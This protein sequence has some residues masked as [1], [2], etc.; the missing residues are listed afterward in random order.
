MLWFYDRPNEQ[1]RV[2]ARYDNDTAEFVVVV[3]WPDGREQTE[4]FSALHEFQAW[5]TS[6]DGAMAAEQWRPNT[7]IVLP[8]GWPDKRLT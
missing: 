6:F 7:P 3:N 1:L 4:R 8:Y 2:E 5:L